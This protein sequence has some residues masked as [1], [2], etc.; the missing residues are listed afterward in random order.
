MSN[1]TVPAHLT[2]HHVEY[3][4]DHTMGRWAYRM[5]NADNS[6]FGGTTTSFEEAK[7]KAEEWATEHNIP[8]E[9]RDV[10]SERE[11]SK[12]RET[13]R[14]EAEERHTANQAAE[15]AAIK[16]MKA[17]VC[18]EVQEA[19]LVVSS[20]PPL[21]YAEDMVALPTLGGIIVPDTR[22]AGSL[23]RFPEDVRLPATKAAAVL[24]ATWTVAEYQGRGVVMTV[25][26]AYERG[27]REAPNWLPNLTGV[28]TCPAPGEIADHLAT[29]P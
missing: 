25:V 17:V 2:F 22:T 18:G 20:L 4:N 19:P 13:A 6:S 26:E 15:R 5:V 16:H 14:R 12:A 8:V 28:H 10:K 29:T 1:H 9:M 24:H 7:A 21:E 23:A 27:L 11:A 3:D